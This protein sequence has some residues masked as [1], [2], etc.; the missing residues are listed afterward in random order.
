MP[1]RKLSK[2]E[3]SSLK[4]KAGAVLLIALFYGAVGYWME[5]TKRQKINIVIW[6]TITLTFGISST[7]NFGGWY[8]FALYALNIL[9][10]INNLMVRHA[11]YSFRQGFIKNHTNFPIPNSPRFNTWFAVIFWIILLTF[12]YLHYNE[13]LY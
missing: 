12:T 9:W 6:W 4:N 11:G 3:E 1:K 10:G 7:F 8:I 2:K 5:S 13:M